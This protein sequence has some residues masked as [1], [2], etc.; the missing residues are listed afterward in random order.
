MLITL[1]IYFVFQYLKV[2][3][4]TKS[5]LIYSSTETYYQIREAVVLFVNN[6]A[7]YCYVI[8]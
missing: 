2:I 6:T 8:Y 5:Y 1:L 3:K 7:K 4:S